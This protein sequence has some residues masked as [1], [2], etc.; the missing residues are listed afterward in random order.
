MF[1]MIKAAIDI[2]YLVALSAMCGG[3]VWFG[4][5]VM[6]GLDSNFMNW[7]KW[8][9]VGL[10]LFFHGWRVLIIVVYPIGLLGWKWGKR[11]PGYSLPIAGWELVDDETSTND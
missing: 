2:V 10:L 1:R 11:V 7:W 5:H 3:M 8:W 6:G 4:E 9:F